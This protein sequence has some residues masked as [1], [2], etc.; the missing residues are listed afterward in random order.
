[1]KYL[2]FI[3]VVFIGCNSQEKSESV[4]GENKERLDLYNETINIH[5]EVMPEMDR[6]MMERDQLLQSIQNDTITSDSITMVQN[7]LKV[8]KLEEAHE[9]MFSWMRKYGKMPHDSLGHD[10][11]MRILNES[12]QAITDVKNKVNEVLK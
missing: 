4:T 6:I 2:L 10:E 7:K 8:S 5:N 12:K 1:M 11:I 3:V 9:A